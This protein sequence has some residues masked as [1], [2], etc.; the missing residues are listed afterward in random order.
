MKNNNAD[1]HTTSVLK[2]I[3]ADIDF[4]D[5]PLKYIA[6]ASVIDEDGVEQTYTGDDIRRLLRSE[7][8]VA[9]TADVMFLLDTRAVYHAIKIEY[10]YVFERI[11]KLIRDAEKN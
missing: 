7:M 9:D 4:T 11:Y 10:L 6:A 1:N 2:D 8:K 3:I 5:I